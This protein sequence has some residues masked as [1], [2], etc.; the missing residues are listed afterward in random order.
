MSPIT[1]LFN[2]PTWAYF[3]WEDEVVNL[4]PPYDVKACVRVIFISDKRC[5][6]H[7]YF[8][9]LYLHIP[10]LKHLTKAYNSYGRPKN[11]GR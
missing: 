11:K 8:T 3:I 4:N 2:L 10:R 5:T 1:M 7:P 9:V 6:Q